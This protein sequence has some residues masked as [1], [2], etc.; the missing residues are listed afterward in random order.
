MHFR[1]EKRMG[2]DRDRSW[3]VSGKKI[4]RERTD[5]DSVTVTPP[6]F[7][8]QVGRGVRRLIT[9]LFSTTPP[10]PYG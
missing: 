7:G 1:R 9:T 5:I 2:D 4:E 10:I 8:G 3:T 6:R